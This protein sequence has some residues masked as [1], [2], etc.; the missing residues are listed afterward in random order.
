MPFPDDFADITLQD[1]PLAP[2]TW[3]KVGGPAQFFVEPREVDELQQ[4]V[5]A[6]HKQSIPVRLLG[7]GS[8]LLISD[9]GVSGAVIRLPRDNFGSFETEGGRV[10]C[11]AAMPLSHLVSRTV[12]QGLVGLEALTGIPGTVGGALHGNVGGRQGDIGRFI[13][14]ATVMTIAGEIFTRTADELQFGYRE[15]SLDELVILD[16]E[17]ELGT[18]DPDEI[19]KRMR[20]IWIAKKTSQP[21]AFQS[22]GCIFKNPR[23][24]SAG[25]LIDRAGLKGTRI[26]GATISDRHANFIITDDGATADD[27]SRLID[28]ARSKV[29]DQLGVELEVEVNR[30]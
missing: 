12:K 21:F 9:D 29:A 26:G 19:A 18:G 23:G 30:W 1:E 4:I 25:E 5:R 7:G 17:L 13:R 11:S 15:S 6:C 10:R 22:A 24:K 2:H 28:L 16:A 14:R 27:V 8:N 3:L 20:K